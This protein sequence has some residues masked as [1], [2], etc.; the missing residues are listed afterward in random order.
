MPTVCIVK[1]KITITELKYLGAEIDDI[2]CIEDDDMLFF[3]SGDAFQAPD[4]NPGSETERRSA[5]NS[6]KSGDFTGIIGGYKIGSFLGKGGFGEVRLGVHQLT[7]E[8]VALKFIMV[9]VV[10]ER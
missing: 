9:R 4:L 7:G 5:E 6:H 2:M 8:Q 1:P 3:S 10:T